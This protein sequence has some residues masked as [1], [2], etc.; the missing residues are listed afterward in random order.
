MDGSSLM[1]WM[2]EDEKVDEKWMQMDE[3]WIKSG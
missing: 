1:K 3:K 2:L